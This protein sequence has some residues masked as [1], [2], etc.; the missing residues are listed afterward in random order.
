MAY[1]LLEINAPF[2]LHYLV[3]WRTQAAFLPPLS[4]TPF[5][6]HVTLHI[7][8]ERSRLDAELVGCI[9]R[10]YA[11]ARAYTCGPVP[12]MDRV[13]AVGV[14]RLPVSAIHLER[15]FAEPVDAPEDALQTFELKVASTGKSVSVKQGT[16]IVAAL[17]EIG[18]K[19]DTSCAEE[20]CGTCIVDVV[21]G[22]PDHRDNFLSKAERA[23]DAVICC[24]VSRLK[25]S[26]VV[27]DL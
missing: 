20:V 7:G 5:A 23:S 4:S 17:A 14:Q 2:V 3:R 22:K 18:V 26:V 10:V 9:A 12:I 27:L 15:F 6:S 13:V 24:C 25:S 21:S 11:S 16:S 19:V 8:V 1:R